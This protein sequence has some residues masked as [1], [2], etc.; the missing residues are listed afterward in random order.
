MNSPVKFY[1]S[2]PDPEESAEGG[3]DPLGLTPISEFL[4]EKLVPGIRERQKNPRF[5]T[6]SV[7]GLSLFE[8]VSSYLNENDWAV[9]RWEAYEWLYV[10]GLIKTME[11]RADIR[12]LPGLDKARNTFKLRIPMCAERYLKTPG[13]F[14]FHGIYKVLARELEFER[15]GVLGEPGA[16]LLNIWAR[17]QG[18]DS[19][20][21]SKLKA[22]LV[23]AIVEATKAGE[24]VQSWSWEH[25]HFFNDHLHHLHPGKKESA[26]IK[27]ALTNRRE[28][29]RSEV[30]DFINSKDANSVWNE[31]NEFSERKV[32]SKMSKTG[33]SQLRQL[34]DVIGI[35]ETFC[36]TLKD[37]FDDCRE[38]L[39]RTKNLCDYQDMVS[40]RSVKKGA[41]NISTQFSEAR[42]ALEVVQQDDRF[43]KLFGEFRSV[44]TE[45]DFIDVLIR[46]H[47]QTQ[48]NKPPNGK[49]SW[50]VIDDTKKIGLRAAYFTEKPGL[51]RNEYVH[52]YRSRP[53]RSFLDDLGA[54]K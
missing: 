15:A 14:G 7:V 41:P 32:H 21:N 28:N 23:R 5:L 49:N 51:N 1:L 34:I 38:Y 45:L 2:E 26:Y 27:M 44:K 18:L 12:G 33:S 16:E 4:A 6:A 35:Y 54:L 47:I 43:D 40:L 20:A 36:R 42:Q 10:S 11:S 50:F 3:I 46:H 31:S 13:V 22:S 9:D 25:W 37:S 19:F 29:L 24:V 39:T 30:F 8:E 17:E 53:V 48:K 52:A